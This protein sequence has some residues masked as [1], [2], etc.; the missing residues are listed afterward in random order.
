MVECALRLQILDFDHRSI[1]A[2]PRPE[3]LTSLPDQ[4]TDR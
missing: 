3:G 4:M 2:A 1:A